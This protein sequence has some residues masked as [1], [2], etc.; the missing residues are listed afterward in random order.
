MR[1]KAPNLLIFTGHAK[2]AGTSVKL[3]TMYRANRDGLN[4]IA[5]ALDHLRGYGWA[6]TTDQMN[7]VAATALFPG[8]GAEH[9]SSAMRPV[10]E[11]ADARY[12]EL[13]PNRKFWCDG[14]YVVIDY[15][16]YDFLLVVG[17]KTVYRGEISRDA[18]LR[19][20]QRL[21]DRGQWEKASRIAKGSSRK[22]KQEA[23]TD[24]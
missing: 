3:G 20:S 14:T 16:E 4:L 15:T 8:M 5:E 7:I 11:P 19:A 9:I 22:T 6:L 23:G 13:H 10:A 1:D 21:R 24:N 12:E 18:L 17:G 2:V